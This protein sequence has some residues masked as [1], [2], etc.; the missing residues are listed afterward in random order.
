VLQGRPSRRTWIAALVVSVVCLAGL[1][2]GLV[3]DWNTPP[4][5]PL[6]AAQRHAT[7][8]SGFSLGLLVGLG[9]GVVLGSLLALRKRD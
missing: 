1:A 7:E 3:S 9:G 2:Y 6:P 8:G 4:A 5:R